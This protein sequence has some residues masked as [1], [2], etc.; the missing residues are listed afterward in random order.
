MP[1]A[2]SQ[3]ESLSESNVSLIQEK[4][5]F[6]VLNDSVSMIYVIIL[7]L[8]SSRVEVSAFSFL[9]EVELHVAATSLYLFNI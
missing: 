8:C 3:L 1:Y 6:K 5:K 9:Q 4:E 2:D 7:M